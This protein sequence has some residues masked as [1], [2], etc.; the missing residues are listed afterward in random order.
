MKTSIVASTTV[1]LQ[2]VALPLGNVRLC[3]EREA[4]PISEK[5]QIRFMYL[6]REENQ[7]KTRCRPAD[8]CVC[9]TANF[10]PV[11]EPHRRTRR[12]LTVYSAED[13][14]ASH[15]ANGVLSFLHTAAD[16][17]QSIGQKTVVRSPE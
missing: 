13:L 5:A 4:E 10:R 16:V 12:E 14:D 7:K 11:A 15:R 2:K 9:R 6:V 17:V 1:A 8:N 3:G